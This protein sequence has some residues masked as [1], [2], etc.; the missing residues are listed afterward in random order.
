MIIVWMPNHPQAMIPLIK[1]GMLAP[2]N[3][4]LDLRNTGKG[5]PYLAP[6]KE[7]RT[8]GSRT[9]A[10]PKKM[11]KTDVAQSK[12]AAIILAASIQVGTQTL[13]PTHMEKYS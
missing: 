12:P 5:I 10:L 6:A 8:M 2:N 11:V 9:M 4:K 3:P 7:S 1:A 13:M